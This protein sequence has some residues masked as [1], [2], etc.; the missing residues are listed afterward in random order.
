MKEQ[1]VS[2]ILK[3]TLDGINEMVKQDE[4]KLEEIKMLSEQIS[5]IEKRIAEINKERVYLSGSYAYA[6]AL[7]ALINEGAFEEKENSEN[8]EQINSEKKIT[9]FKKKK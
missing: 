4:Q 2:L 6:N 3:D 7:V 5:E 1:K 8:T 9:E